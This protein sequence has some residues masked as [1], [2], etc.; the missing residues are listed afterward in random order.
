MEKRLAIL[1]SVADQVTVNFRPAAA[2]GRLPP[3]NQPG[4]KLLSDG[5]RFHDRSIP[6]TTK[7]VARGRSRL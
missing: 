6:A 4:L 7:R 2:E 1:A 5:T 3:S